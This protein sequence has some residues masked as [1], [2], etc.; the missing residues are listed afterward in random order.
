M[1]NKL[2]ADEPPDW[3]IRLNLLGFTPLTYFGFVLAFVILSFNNIL[4][5]G[6]AARLIGLDD[7]LNSSIMIES[8]TGQSNE[9]KK[10]QVEY[11]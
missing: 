1:N 7:N 10:F 2:Q 6:W 9:N 8:M 3:M 4:G 5:N 11:C